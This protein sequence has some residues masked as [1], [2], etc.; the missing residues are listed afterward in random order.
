MRRPLVA[1]VL[2][3]VFTAGGRSAPVPAERLKAEK[4]L[5]AAATKLTGVWRGGPCEGTIALR[6]DRTYSWTGI[7]PGGEAHAGTWS[8]RGDPATPTLALTCKEADAPDLEGTTVEAK[9]ARIGDDEFELK[10]TEAERPKTFRRV[11]DE[12]K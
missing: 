5:A 2:L 1:G 9:F 6:A 7:G 12:P 11:K 10:E 8:L 4:Q 3:V